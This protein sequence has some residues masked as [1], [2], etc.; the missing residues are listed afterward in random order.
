MHIIIAMYNKRKGVYKVSSLFTIFRNLWSRR[1][2]DVCYHASLFL[3]C[4]LSQMYNFLN[5]LFFIENL[6]KFLN[7][8][9]NHN[10]GNI[11]IIGGEGYIGN[12]VAQNLLMKGYTVISYDNLLYNNHLCVLNHIVFLMNFISFL[13]YYIDDNYL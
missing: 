9:A 13:G 4:H 8:M 7:T 1:Y 10:K 2:C 5:F 3:F 6:L 11:F 12:V